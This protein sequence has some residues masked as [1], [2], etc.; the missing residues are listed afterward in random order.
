MRH[1]WKN[2][3]CIYCGATKSKYEREDGLET[4]AYQLI[5]SPKPEEIFKIKFDVII[6]NP[7]YQLSDGGAQASAKPIYHLFV[8]Q[9][10]R[11]NPRYLAMIIPAR[12]YAGGKGLDEFRNKMLDDEHIRELHDFPNTSD[13]FPG[14]N[15][16]GGVCYFLWDKEYNNQQELVQVVTHT[17]KNTQA[18]QRSLKYRDLDIFLRYQQ[19]IPILEKVMSSGQNDMLSEHISPRKPF[20]IDAEFIKTSK[21]QNKPDN[22]K[23]AVPCYGKGKELSYIEFDEIPSHQDWIGKWKIFAP[24]ANNIGTE[25]NDDN[26]NVFIG[27]DEVCTESYLVIGAEMNLTQETATNL[28]SYLQTKFVRF[29]HSLAKASQDATS[30]TYRFIPMQDFSKSWTDEEL[31]KM[32]GFTEGEVAFIEAQIKPMS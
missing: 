12:W 29:L 5:H 14:V 24:R 17:N 6:S 11:L 7:P 21:L 2:Q 22:L 10:E 8:E 30:K 19:S 1:K 25:L 23:R 4:H 16:R 9:A 26:L 18:T 28:I 13:C 27:K 32:Y 15:I 20:G 31:F 3:K